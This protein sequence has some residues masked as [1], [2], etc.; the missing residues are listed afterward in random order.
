MAQLTGYKGGL[1]IIPGTNPSTKQPWTAEELF[2][3]ALTMCVKPKVK[4]IKKTP[5]LWFDAQ[6]LKKLGE[7]AAS[8]VESALLDAGEGLKESLVGLS[9]LHQLLTNMGFPIEQPIVP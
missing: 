7:K 9:S 5:V 2:Q 3:V 6:E 1:A 8:Q 4:S